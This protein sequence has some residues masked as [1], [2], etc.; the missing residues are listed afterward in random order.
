[1]P[2]INKILS[3]V[4]QAK[5]AIKSL[6]GIQSKLTGTG[7][8]INSMGAT[9]N[10]TGDV[11]DK[12]KEQSAKAQAS[13][14]KR[15]QTLDKN[16]ESK[17]TKQYSK[18]APMIENIDYQYPMG[19]GVENFLVFET[20]PRVA[21][22][23][24]NNKNL[25]SG[26]SSISVALY[27]PSTVDTSN[28][29]EYEAA[30]IGKGTRSMLAIKDAFKGGEDGS[31]MEAMGSALENSIQTG[32]DS[33]MQMA[34]GGANNF[35]Q[36]RAVNPMEEQMFKGI[37]FREFNFSYEFL[38]R[39]AKE[40]KMVQDIIWT[41]RTAMLPDTY[42]NAEGASAIENYFNY[43]N[44][45]KAYWEGPISKQFDDFLPMVC[46]KCDTKSSTKLFEDGYPLSVTM[47][48]TMTEIKI[49]TQE[50]FQQISKSS[51]A[52]DIGGSNT[53]LAMRRNE[54]NEQM[55]DRQKKK[56]TPPKGG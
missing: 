32:I 45:F 39:D 31:T 43:P 50:T 33:L 37:G 28:T 7:Y 47:D 46:K 2:N 3:K 30:G 6:K 16:K 15:R 12:L 40:S 25:L 26:Q 35:L 34:T 51:Q 5:S 36:G 9:G 22:D 23:G 13:L 19:D 56:P 8:D 21:R 52:T 48:I 14:D 1:M 29:A 53:S 49:I 41:F 38:P 44:I 42:S 10:A 4:N 27:V 17:K 20:I 18:T 11:A 24:E 55:I 54:T